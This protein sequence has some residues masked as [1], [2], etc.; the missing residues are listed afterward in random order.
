MNNRHKLVLKHA[1]IQAVG[2]K[3]P[4][5]SCGQLSEECIDCWARWIEKQFGY[6]DNK[7]WKNFMNL[8]AD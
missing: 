3:C 5:R 2:S 4:W 8:E 7:D 6:L 1:L